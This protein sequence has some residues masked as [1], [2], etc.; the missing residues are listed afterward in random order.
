MFM[1][2]KSARAIIFKDNQILLMHR[3]KK[4]DEYYTFP[5]G[6]LDDNETYEDC[7][8]REVLEEFGINVSCDKLIY[9]YI[10]NHTE[11][12]FFLTK[13]ISGEFGT[14]TGEE[15]CD[16]DEKYGKYIPEKIN[17]ESIRDINLRPKIIKD[18][19]IENIKS[20]GSYL[21][22]YEERIEDYDTKY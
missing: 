22:E 4:D 16:R 6:G 17:V 13:Y 10:S 18:M 7:V 12:Q 1:K 2:R 14:G 3:I 8:V 9:N 5:G 11:Q 20:N 15:Y 19:L 21:K